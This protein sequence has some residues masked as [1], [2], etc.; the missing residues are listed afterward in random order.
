M[1]T[2]RS[3]LGPLPV[4]TEPTEKPIEHWL[5]LHWKLVILVFVVLT[6][7]LVGLA[8]HEL[9]VITPLDGFYV[10]LHNLAG[11]EMPRHVAGFRWT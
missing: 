8:L 4:Q 9:N 7:F 10:W 1:N 6:A 3:V 11:G 2:P 5:G